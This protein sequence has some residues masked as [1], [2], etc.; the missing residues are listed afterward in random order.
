MDTFEVYDK[1]SGHY[2]TVPAISAKAARDGY[3]KDNGL[4][5]DDVKVYVHKLVECVIE[6]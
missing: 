4:D 3:A 2:W 6:D 5:K 1:H